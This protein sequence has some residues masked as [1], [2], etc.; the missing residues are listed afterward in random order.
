VA[1]TRRSHYVQIQTVGFGGTT[2]GMRTA[3]DITGPW[4][5]PATV[6][7]PPESNR[8]GVLVYAAK[9]HPEL[10]GADLVATYATN[11]SDF[12]TLASDLT[13]YFPRFV[14]LDYS[15]GPGASE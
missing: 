14:R 13:L 3:P 10:A 2:I 5:L 15:R 6:Y 9:G 1:G 12:A 4:P 7:T 8:G 11:D